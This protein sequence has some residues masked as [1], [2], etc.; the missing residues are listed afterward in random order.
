MPGNPQLN[1]FAAE[2]GRAAAAAAAPDQAPSRREL[3]KISG[4][5]KTA[6]ADWLAGKSLPRSWDDGAVLLVDAIIKIAARYGK[7]F[8]DEEAV[9]QRCKDA[10]YS[11]KRIPQLNGIPANYPAV[12]SGATTADQR[13]ADD[14]PGGSVPEPKYLAFLAGGGRAKRVFSIASVVAVSAMAS[15]SILWWWPAAWHR[16]APAARPLLGGA[17]SHPTPLVSAKSGKCVVVDG[18]VDEARASL[19]GCTGT[20]GRLWYLRPVVGSIPVVNLFHIV[21]ASNNRCLSYSDEMY[22]GAHVVVQRS[23]AAS[24][25]KGQLWNFVTDGNRVDNCIHGVFIN[26]R[27]SLLLDINGEKVDDGTPVIQWWEN[28]KQNQ[29]FCVMNGVGG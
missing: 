26:M 28:G 3:A 18:D 20:P 23:C 11:A 7:R 6:I 9:R 8:P 15:A 1:P 29:R 25:E 24:Q 13:A 10:Y 17:L 14:E 5:G 4:V 22:G 21:N 12:P 27:S 2:L 19:S 16:S